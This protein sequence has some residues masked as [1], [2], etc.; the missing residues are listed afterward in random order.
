MEL[1]RIKGSIHQLSYINNI[2][3]PLNNL[4]IQ[5]LTG[6]T[7]DIE[8]EIHDINGNVCLLLDIEM[9]LKNMIIINE[10]RCIPNLKKLVFDNSVIVKD[11]IYGHHIWR[12]F[13]TFRQSDN[14][15]NNNLYSM[16]EKHLLGNN[17]T[18]NNLACIGGECYIFPKLYFNNF[19]EFVIKSDYD[20]ISNHARLNL[21][22]ESDIK[23]IH[24]HKVSYGQLDLSHYI[25]KYFPIASLI[26]N[27]RTLLDC[28]INTI[29]HIN[30]KKIIIISCNKK[31]I[32][33]L[34]K[35]Y[36]IVIE[37][38]SQNIELLIVKK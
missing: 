27:V 29:K 6:L 12:S 8:I 2:I 9:T 34:P 31:N 23:N 11:Y 37:K 15:T 3:S 10:I 35:D 20:D 33:R 17:L 38:V 7:D 25:H 21:K 18:D 14:F 22:V 26:I 32:R 28:H 4:V 19:S 30:C 5:F 1:N 13:K 24:I 36:D 16:I